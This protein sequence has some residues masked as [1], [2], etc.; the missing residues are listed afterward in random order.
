MH[1]LNGRIIRPEL[2]DD[3]EPALAKRSLSDV[4]RIN[5]LLGGH[6]VLR[7]TLDRVVCPPERFSVLDVGAASGDMGRVI[8]QMYPGARVFSLD[9]RVDHLRAADAPKL[10]GDAFRMPFRAKTFDYVFCSLFLHH[11][12]DQQV[13]ELLAT[14]RLLARRQVV[15]TDLE[16]NPL[17]YYFLP[18]TRW[19]LGWD[20]ITLH[21]GPISVEASFVRNE[22]ENLARR[23]GLENIIV[24]QHRPSFRLSL[25]AD[26]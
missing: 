19:I 12:T 9:Y 24:H 10:A 13:V 7:R 5:R 25:V 14:F 1:C 6:G 18:A 11:F 26:V 8:R 17:A 3:T 20:P 21:D 22:L 2:L 23:A 16:R 4:V 15:V